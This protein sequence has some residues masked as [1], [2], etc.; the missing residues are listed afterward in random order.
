M[1]GDVMVGDDDAVRTDDRAA[2]R[3]FALH[4]AATL[5]GDC[6]DGNADKAWVYRLRGPFNRQPIG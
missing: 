6:N 2:A 4:F 5:E 1:A 3:G